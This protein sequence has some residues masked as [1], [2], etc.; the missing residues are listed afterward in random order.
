MKRKVE[1]NGHEFV[2]WGKAPWV[3]IDVKATDKTPECSIIVESSMISYVFGAG[4][5]NTTP[6]RYNALS[7][8]TEKGAL[9]PVAF[10]GADGRDRA[11]QIC[12]ILNFKLG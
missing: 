6:H 7:R 2:I 9:L 12:K 5:Y 10:V 11:D 1:I 3:V 4:R 8:Q